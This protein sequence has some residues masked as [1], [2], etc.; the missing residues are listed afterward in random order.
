VLAI[1]LHTPR[2]ELVAP[3]YEIARLELDDLPQ[4]EAA[5]SA[6]LA[7]GWPPPLMNRETQLRFLSYLQADPDASPWEAWYF[8]L[9]AERLVVG[10]G[11]FKGRPDE[12][13]IAEVGYSMVDAY[14][15][16]GL[17][18]E[19]VGALITWAFSNPDV[20]QINAETFPDNVASLRV[21][22]KNGLSF[23]GDG[24]EP[25]TVLYAITRENYNR[26]SN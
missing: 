9:E 7:Q 25:G 11:G 23:R 13:G 16:R 24:S 17:C 4:F 8:I 12:Q 3:P 20:N 21:M 14:Q 26:P 5:M 10:S 18:T 15:G 22:E 2:L 1:R 19:G 6:R